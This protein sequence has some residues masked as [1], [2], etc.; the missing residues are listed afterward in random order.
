M[1]A[2][3]AATGLPQDLGGGENFQPRV[4][5]FPFD[6]FQAHFQST[7]TDLVRGTADRGQGRLVGAALLAIV[8]TDKPHVQRDAKA[9]TF[10]DA[11]GSHGHG[12][13]CAHHGI[14]GNPTAQDRFHGRLATFQVEVAHLPQPRIGFDPGLFAPCQEIG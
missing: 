8:V 1:R 6:P 2:H 13:V 5:G 9:A 11:N 4:F 14:E 12:I 10:Q 3:E 7:E